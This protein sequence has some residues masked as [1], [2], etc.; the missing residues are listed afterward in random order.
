MFS[1]IRQ[2]ASSTGENMYWPPGT[3]RGG[4]VCLHGSE[5]GWAGWNDLYCALFAAHGFTA[6]SHNYTKVMHWPM[7]PDIDDVPL[8]STVGALEAMQ[9]EMAPFGCGVGLFGI[10][11]G[12]EHTLLLAQLFAEDGGAELPDAVAVHSPPDAT[13]P[14]FIVSD[15]QT[16]QPWAGDRARPAW[17]WRGTHE[18]TRPGTPLCPTEV[19]YPVFINPGHG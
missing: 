7:P 8:E 12:A 3:P 16:R 15:F 6:V 10:S 17:S 14:A 9:A 4:I 13:W 11:R 2:S 18:R 5:G 19:P 1:S